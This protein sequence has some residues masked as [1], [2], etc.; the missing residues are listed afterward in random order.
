MVSPIGSDF[1]QQQVKSISAVAS[2]HV[3]CIELQCGTDCVKSNLDVL[4]L[5]QENVLNR[6]SRIALRCAVPCLSL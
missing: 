5:F 4:S 3:R 1:V 6:I 2:L